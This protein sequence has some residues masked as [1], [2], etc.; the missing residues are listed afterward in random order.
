MGETSVAKFYSEG[1]KGPLSHS[2]KVREVFSGILVFSLRPSSV[3]CSS[4]AACP[5]LAPTPIQC[6]VVG[7]NPPSNAGDAQGT[8]V[9]TLG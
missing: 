6:G 4:L 1:R 9:R 5:P 7:K 3:S 8:W 2:R